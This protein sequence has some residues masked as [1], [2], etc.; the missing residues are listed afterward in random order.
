MS[1]NYRPDGHHTER[2]GAVHVAPRRRNQQDQ[3]LAEYAKSYLGL[4]DEE[5]AINAGLTHTCYWKRCGELREK[6]YISTMEAP[7]MAGVEL[8]RK[9]RAGVNRIISWITA[10][11]ED[12]LRNLG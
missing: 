1:I 3:L 4:T 11:G 7:E 10:E 8:T 5:A 12:Y 2:E 6:G 9:G